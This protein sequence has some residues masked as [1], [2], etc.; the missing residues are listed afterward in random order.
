MKKLF[1]VSAVLLSSFGM[2]NAQSAKATTTQP[3][4]TEIAAEKAPEA[5]GKQLVAKINN[6]VQLQGDQWGKVNNICV[7]FFTKH[8]ALKSQKG[9]IDNKVFE[10]KV[11]ELKSAREKA[12]AA[13]LTPEQNKKLEAAKAADKATPPNKN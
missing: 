6:A 3:T 11:E 8:D 4:R 10:T 12:L 5:R 2:T 7:D 13:V 9:T 1:F